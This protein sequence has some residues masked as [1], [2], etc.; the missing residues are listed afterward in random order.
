[1][2]SV[3]F[4]CLTN[5]S[6]ITVAILGENSSHSIFCQQNCQLQP[7]RGIGAICCLGNNGSSGDLV[8]KT[9]K[10]SLIKWV[11]PELQLSQH[12][13]L[14]C[15]GAGVQ[16]RCWNWVLYCTL[17]SAPPAEWRACRSISHL[18]VFQRSYDHVWERGELQRPDRWLILT[19]LPTLPTL[20]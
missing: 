5:N 13:L 10:A 2:A 1:M 6:E 7:S 20:H 9:E 15:M 17:T 11:H 18:A 4:V 16:P 14:I 3:V 12:I 8:E 19:R